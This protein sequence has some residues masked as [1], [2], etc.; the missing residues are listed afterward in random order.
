[1]QGF[2]GDRAPVGVPARRR[3]TCLWIDRTRRSRE[4]A[5]DVPD[6]AAEPLPPVDPEAV[7]A[8]LMN[9]VPKIVYSWTLRW[10]ARGPA[11]IINE[12]DAAL[13]HRV[14]AVRARSPT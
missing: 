12:V 10:T 3:R 6:V 2:R 4:I 5:G 1:M 11:T 8:L 14:A 9:S 7:G 13:R